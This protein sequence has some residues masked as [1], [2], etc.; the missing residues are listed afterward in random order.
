MDPVQSLCV[1]PARRHARAPLAAILAAA[2]LLA[3]ITVNLMA[4]GGINSTRG[5]ILH[6]QAVQAVLVRTRSALVDAETGHRGYLLVGDALYLEPLHQAEKS[7]PAAL[8]ELR[9]LTANDPSQKPRI[10]DLEGLAAQKMAEIRRSVELFQAGDR[11][12]AVAI[13]RTHQGKALMDGARSLIEEMRAEEA[14]LLERRSA[15][16]R[17]NLDIAMW[18]DAGAGLGLLVLGFLL[19]LINRDIA[20]REALEAA[21]RDAA[22]F[23]EQFV[24]VLG[25]D[26]RN[27]LNAVTMGAEL[28]LRKDRGPQDAEPTL[29]RI[30]S[31][32]SRM[33]RM[34][35]QLLDLTRARLAGGIPV[36][37]RPGT[38]LAEVAR[39]AVE[40]LRVAHPEA[41]L[42]LHAAGPIR[43]DWDADRMAQV[44]SNLV[45]NAISHGAGAPVD[46]Q[47]KGGEA[48]AILEVHNGGSP[49]P[50]ELLPRIFD[51]FRRAAEGRTAAAQGLGL[52]LFITRQIV[53][54]HGGTIDV[55]SEQP[56]GTTFKVTLPSQPGQNSYAEARKT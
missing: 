37:P 26:L 46:V 28:L 35:D 27:P 22:K 10:A 44:I 52:G 38:N 3:L 29:R 11:A 17:R 36:Q 56:E 13:V 23:Q 39:G 33:R 16:A 1:N 40:E 21:L 4:L 14:L 45:A 51:P 12:A 55:I 9:T 5:L 2:I 42:N 7:L 8:A 41:Q 6:T 24:G 50:P 43:G 49:I 48:A 31:S 19:Y 30:A 47:V 15:S 18:I 53:L 20:R 34:V 32:A 54:A 25:H